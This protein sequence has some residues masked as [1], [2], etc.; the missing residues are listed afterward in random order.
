MNNIATRVFSTASLALYLG[1]FAIVAKFSVQSSESISFNLPSISFS[2]FQP[3]GPEW[4]NGMMPI[5]IKKEEIKTA[6]DFKIKEVKA[7]KHAKVELTVDKKIIMKPELIVAKPV[8]TKETFSW[9][10]VSGAKELPTEKIQSYLAEVKFDLPATMYL[11]LYNDFKTETEVAVV[12]ENTRAPADLSKPIEDK[13]SVAQASNVRVEDDLVLYDYQDEPKVEVVKETTVVEK[14]V[15]KVAEV[16]PVKNEVKL[17]HTENVDK[18]EEVAIGDLITFDYSQ[19]QAVAPKVSA[20]AVA[21]PAPVKEVKKASNPTNPATQTNEYSSA[22]Q[23]NEEVAARTE[24]FVGKNQAIRSAVAITA[25]SVDGKDL[26]DL[27][28]FE[29]Q[30]KDDANDFAQ[31]LN[32]GQ[33]VFD[34]SLNDSVA[35]R[36]MKLVSRGHVTTHTDLVLEQND[37]PELIPVITDMYFSKLQS[38]AKTTGGLLVKVDSNVLE[39]E[40]DK[41][42]SQKIFFD[43]NMIK[44]KS[45]TYEFVYFANVPAGNVMINFVTKNKEV[46][47]ILHINDNELTYEKNIIEDIGQTKVVMYEDNLLSKEKSG[48]NINAAQMTEFTQD[49]RVEKLSLNTY[50]V[51][52]GNQSY[53]SRVYLELSHLE[54]PIFVGFGDNKKVTIPSDDYSRLILKNFPEGKLNSRCMVQ[55]NLNK[56]AVELHHSAEGVEDALMTS[57]QMVDK[58]GSFHNSLSG[59]T[60][61]LFI[62]GEYQGNS[63][64]DPNGIIHIKVK[65][66]DGTSDYLKTFCSPNTYLVEQL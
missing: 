31:D 63:K 53:G 12:E 24:G 25:V 40:I 39:V 61:K 8:D 38:N 29:V 6:T 18:I 50:N 10:N 49:P 52:I 19:A 7:I 26:V 54:E 56:K 42:S 64:S 23:A 11:A 30:F 15:E 22:V 45:D 35:T 46:R 51:G 60:E 34:Y 3:E 16:Q 2:N 17:I 59:K 43:G 57:A 65:Y 37:T 4:M 21:K 62:Q 13:V 36:S 44:T 27:K 14:A 58:D 28:G 1:L 5:E 41:T 66:A 9:R 47:K 32:N 55:V 48:L 20:A 33:V